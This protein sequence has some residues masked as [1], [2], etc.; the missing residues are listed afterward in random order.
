[1]GTRLGKSLNTEKRGRLPPVRLAQLDVTNSAPDCARAPERCTTESIPS[2][3]RGEEDE[4][5]TSIN[6]DLSTPWR[7]YRSLHLRWAP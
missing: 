4:E 1:M 6:G 5:I 7:E 3:S 2:K